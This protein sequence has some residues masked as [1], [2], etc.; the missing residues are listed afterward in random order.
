MSWIIGILIYIVGFIVCYFIGTRT[1]KWLNSKVEKLTELDR[2]CIF[3]VSCFSWLGVIMVILAL[4]QSG[5]ILRMGKHYFNKS[6]KYIGPIL[7]KLE[8][9]K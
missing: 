3:I 2:K 5:G 6:W 1:S 7:K 9:K 8:E 4:L